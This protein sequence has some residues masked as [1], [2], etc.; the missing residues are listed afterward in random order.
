MISWFYVLMEDHKENN[1]NEYRHFP[2]ETGLEAF[3]RPLLTHRY[4]ITTG[5][6]RAG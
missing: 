3:K 4:G 5:W 2:A 6:K 1:Q